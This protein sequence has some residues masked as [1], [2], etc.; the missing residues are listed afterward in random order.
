METYAK[1]GK[2]DLDFEMK[3]RFDKGKMLKEANEL[4]VKA[5]IITKDVRDDK[6]VYA[7]N[8]TD[9]NEMYGGISGPFIDSFIDAV[10]IL[11]ESDCYLT[12]VKVM[13]NR[14]RNGREFLY[15]F[16]I[17]YDKYDKEKYGIC[18]TIKMIE[19]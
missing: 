3:V 19:R 14:S 13:K 11:K 12:R 6:T 15:A 1:Y 8:I 9:G 2:V 4:D 17:G 7:I 18:E 16:P 5:V 10:N